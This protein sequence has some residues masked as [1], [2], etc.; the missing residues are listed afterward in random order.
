M[1][2]ECMCLRLPEMLRSSQAEGTSRVKEQQGD[3]HQRAGRQV[4]GSARTWLVLLED[5]FSPG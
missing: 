4:E 5:G 2:P 1:L 3:G